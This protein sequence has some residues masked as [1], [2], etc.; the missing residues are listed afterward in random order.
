MYEGTFLAFFFDIY[1]VRGI[2]IIFRD[3]NERHH[4]PPM[5]GGEIV[6]KKRWTID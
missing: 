3:G 4:T 5:K 2:M 6:K 1:I